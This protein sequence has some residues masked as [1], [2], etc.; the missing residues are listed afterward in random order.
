M[1]IG[2]ERY[3]LVNVYL[4]TIGGACTCSIH[5][6][7]TS[8]SIQK[9]EATRSMELPFTS[10]SV[11]SISQVRCVKESSEFSTRRVYASV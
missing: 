2:R 5:Y 3:H 8:L 6:L 1:C 9:N 10:K 4:R 7:S 11:M